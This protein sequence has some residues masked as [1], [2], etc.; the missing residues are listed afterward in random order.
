MGQFQFVHW[1]FLFMLFNFIGWCFE[2]TIESVYHRRFINRGF[3][4]GPYIPIYGTGGIFM[5]LVCVPFA[6]SALSVFVVGMATCTVLEYCVGAIM[7]ALFKKQF[8]DYSMMRFVYKNRVS[9]VSSLVWGLMSLFLVYFLYNLVVPLALGINTDAIEIFS[10][11]AGA[12]MLAD[13]IYSISRNAT[14]EL[15]LRKLSRR[16][17]RL[18]MAQRLRQLSRPVTFLQKLVLGRLLQRGILLRLQGTMIWKI[19]PFA[20]DNSFEYYFDDLDVE[21]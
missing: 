18:I 12:V 3:L 4:K 14:L 1:L 5:M 16:K 9:L 20:H 6:K 7:E 10:Y 21:E 8:W 17:I 19:M 13:V 11:T 15:R 2:S